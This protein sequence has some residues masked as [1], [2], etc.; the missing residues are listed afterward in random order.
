MT[1]ARSRRSSI[2]QPWLATTLIACF[3]VPALAA[4]AASSRKKAKPEPT[5]TVAEPVDTPPSAEAREQEL[6]ATGDAAFLARDYVAAVRAYEAAYALYP[7]ARVLYNQ[8]RSLQALGR[9]GEALTA[10]NRFADE[11]DTSLKARVSGLDELRAQL[12]A[13]V[14]EVT[15]RVNEPGAEVMFGKQ[16]LGTTP[17]PGPVLLEAGPVT[18]RIVKEGFFAFERQLTLPG[19]GGE[20]FDVTLSS[21]ERNDKVSIAS[22]VKGALVSIDGRQVGHAPTE[23]MLP[24]GTHRVVA[25]R[26]G[27]ADASTQVIVRAGETRAVTLD[28][29]EEHSLLGQWWFWTAVGVVAAAGTT[30]AVLIATDRPQNSNGDFNPSSIGAPLIRY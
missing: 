28:P 29:I 24:P 19:G 6:K 16:L 3:T 14:T 4:P 9:N 21:T 15:V 12:R 22:H 1:L 7:D 18:L 13:R 17:L 10:L 8:A 30:T 20:T 25:H 23:A 11:A 5:P 27:F 26:T 2:A